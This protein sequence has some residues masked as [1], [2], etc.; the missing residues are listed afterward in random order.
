MGDL[1]L[2]VDG[3]QSSTTAVIGDRCGRI[4]GFGR[5]GPCNHVRAPEG[6]ARFCSAMTQ[7]LQ[8]ACQNAGLD[9]ARVVFASTA[10]GFSGGPADKVDV[11][12]E[13]LQTRLLRA[14]SDTEMAH[15]GAL[16]GGDGVVVIAG[17]GSVAFGR[18]AEGA[19]ARAGG[20]GPMF[21]DDGAAFGVV[22]E[23]LQAALRA[24]EGWGAD[25]VLLARLLKATGVDHV[26]NLVREFYTEQFP[27]S[28]IASYAPLVDEAA[29]E[30]DA[31]ALRIMREAAAYL[32]KLTDVVRRRLFADTE[33]VRASFVGGMF[34]SSLIL[35]E[36]RLA[37][38]RVAG[39]VVMPPLYGPAV[40]ALLE[41]YREAGMNPVLANVPESEK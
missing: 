15:S 8:A 5:G 18:N 37:A 40:G 22:R 16:A 27:V 34:R 2:G 33:A 17:T 29:R 24:C 10:A 7:C 32:A 26:H 21:G 20:W 9:A 39:C 14:T 11:L 13:I 23:A 19:T 28:R 4:V 25:T 6:R 36:Y 41:A 35:E 3:G 38:Q 31:V 12:R 1:F 30:G